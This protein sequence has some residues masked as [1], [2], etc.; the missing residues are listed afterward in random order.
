MREDV[1]AARREGRIMI[2]AAILMGVVVAMWVPGSGIMDPMSGNPPS[3]SW[4]LPPRMGP[5]IAGLAIY[6]VG[7]ARMIRIYRTSHLE[8]ETS[9]WR[10]R[11]I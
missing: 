3:V 2:A 8:P 6:L 4:L 11:E 9:S 10:Y 1:R 7:L 5:V